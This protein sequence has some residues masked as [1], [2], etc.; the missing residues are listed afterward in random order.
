LLASL[1]SLSLSLVLLPQRA[2]A[3]DEDDKQ[4]NDGTDESTSSTKSHKKKHKTETAEEELAEEKPTEKLS[5]L[6]DP[7]LGLSA[8]AA[9]SLGLL[10]K[11]YGPGEISTGV[12]GL[13][14][15]WNVGRLWTTPDDEFWKYALLAELAYDY[16]GQSDGTQE[17]HTSTAY[18]YINVRGLFGYPVKDFLLVYGAVGGGLTVESVHYTVDGKVTPLTGLKPNLDY[19]LGTRLLFSFTPQFALS[20]RLELMR[21]RRGYMDDTFL[22]FTLGGSF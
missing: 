4:M 1:L 18:H 19:G 3:Q 11:S 8:E 7:R 15:D 5:K 21:F 10:D 22:S 12:V 20:L 2:W 9:V 16:T 13:R 17:I 14:V 6:D